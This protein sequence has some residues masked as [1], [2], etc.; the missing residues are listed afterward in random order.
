MTTK[1]L[2]IG[3]GVVG[4]AG[5]A[6]AGGK[7][8]KERV[9]RRVFWFCV[10]G[11]GL[12]VVAC[13]QESPVGEGRE[14][15]G[16]RRVQETS[17]PAAVSEGLEALVRQRGTTVVRQAFSLL[18]S[19]L[20]QALQQGGVSNALQFCSVHALP[21]TAMVADTNQVVVSRRSHKARNP[22]NRAEPEELKMLDEF[23]VA[24][25]RGE[26]PMA[27]VKTDISGRVIFYAPIVLNNPLCL[28]CHGR[29]R[30]EIAREHLA[31]L[32][33]VYPEDQ[34]TGFK[35]GDLRGLWRIDFARSFLEAGGGL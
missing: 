5:P 8:L 2:V 11:C 19:N 14:R 24:L 28:S 27:R 17:A 9:M 16:D 12:G 35:L 31:L 21:L 6:A 26:I 15:A 18:S 1:R 22:R 23:E 13:R 10:I 7:S 20:L 29:P 25:R 4:E 34:A 32:K 30:E 33:E 3:G